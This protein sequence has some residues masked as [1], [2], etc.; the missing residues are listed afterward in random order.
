MERD[1]HLRQR[2][3]ASEKRK[4]EG[5]TNDTSVENENERREREPRRLTFPGE[6]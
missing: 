3:N 1:A 2:G 5:R 4:E 6:C